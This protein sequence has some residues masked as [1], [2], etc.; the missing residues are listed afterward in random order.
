M[1]FLLDIDVCEIACVEIKVHIFLPDIIIF[2]LKSGRK[3]RSDFKKGIEI[4]LDYKK[5]QKEKRKIQ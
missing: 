1:R 5:K 3:V 4:A 2:T